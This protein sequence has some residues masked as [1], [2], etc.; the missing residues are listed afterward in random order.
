MSECRGPASRRPR[1]RRAGAGLVPAFCLALA[2]VAPPADA[3]R[4][5][6]RVR[7]LGEEWLARLVERSP[8][9][10]SILGLRDHDHRLVPVTQATLDEDRAWNRAFAARLARIPAER[11]SPAS[12]LER[13]LLAAEAART[14][15]WLEDI[16]P[17]ER[18]P[19]AY[20]PLI[21]GSV[22][23]VLERPSG[24]PCAR[25]RTAAQRLTQM[26]EVL[27]AA[28]INLRDPPAPLVDAALAPLEGVLRFYRETVPALA[29]G[30]R[31]PR[32]Q[33]DLAQADTA[34]VRALESF[35]AHLRER[36][37]GDGVAIGD[38]A[39]QR[40]LDAERMD[41]LP[42]DTL[43]A[44]LTRALEADRARV[45][46]AA[47]Q[48]QDAPA[49]PV[50]IDRW[51]LDEAIARVGASRQRLPLA[52]PGGVELTSREAPPFATDPVALH[53]PGPW[54]ARAHHAWLD[55][56]PRGEIAGTRGWTP[57]ELELVA[58]RE[59]W[60]GRLARLQVARA[61]PSPV[62]RALLW[63]RAGDE[64][65]GWALRRLLEEGHGAGDPR[66]ASAAARSSLREHGVALAALGLHRGTLTLTDAVH[67]LIERCGLDAADASVEAR[68]AARQPQIMSYTYAAL[69]LLDLRERL[70]AELGAGQLA[71]RFDDA[72][73]RHGG[74]PMGLVRPAV[75]R[76]LGLPVHPPTTSGASR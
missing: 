50:A 55:I 31:D 33:A 67:L 71:R 36:R 16:R 43:E 38:S 23:T 52:V 19:A 73:L 4:E 74:A 44:R 40:W 63:S 46:G 3:A 15:A 57:E 8:E 30:C 56:A 48:P 72:V 69:E 65:A 75:R 1:A 20:L 6:A 14:V 37:D 64:W 53:A 2:C 21:A 51:R 18:D 60:P 27:R 7:A 12:A 62:R 34:A 41:P 17:F 11:L 49:P 45:A 76:E 39:L 10:A 70:R 68:R 58:M 9:R 13:D 61:D 66:F 54:E 5:D 28:R 25:V 29:T 42:L 26:T 59:G 32:V 24:S 22:R 47:A 35:L